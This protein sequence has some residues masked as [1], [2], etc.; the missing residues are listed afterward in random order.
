[1][2]NLP[3]FDAILRLKNYYISKK[4]PPSMVQDTLRKAYKKRGSYWIAS[5]LSWYK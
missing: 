3:S 1:M 4:L 5:N 2:K